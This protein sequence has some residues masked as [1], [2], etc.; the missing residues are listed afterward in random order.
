MLPKNNR[1]TTQEFS[2]V[3]QKGVAVCGTFV[4]VHT[5]QIA[6]S[7]ETSAQIARFACTIGKK[8]LKGAVGRNRVRRRL[9]GAVDKLCK[10]HN[11]PPYN[12]IIRAKLSLNI[13][14]PEQ[15]EHDIAT[16]ITRSLKRLR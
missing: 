14:T 10:L 1:L 4:C 7:T 3:Y 6:Q 12:F 11:Y 5:A 13:V 15:L 9:Y 8:Q 2:Q 16:V